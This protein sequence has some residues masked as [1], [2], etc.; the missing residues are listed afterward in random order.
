M[1][2]REENGITRDEKINA[3][4][5]TTACIGSCSHGIREL[6][7][8]GNIDILR[9]QPQVLTQVLEFRKKQSKKKWRR[10]GS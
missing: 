10:M 5:V 8:T 4:C 9:L 1:T 7:K 2:T 6:W 3:F